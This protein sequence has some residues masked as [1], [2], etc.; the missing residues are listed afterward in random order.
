M[1][2]YS[3]KEPTKFSTQPGNMQHYS[4]YYSADTEACTVFHSFGHVGWVG[5]NHDFDFGTKFTM[6]FCMVQNCIVNFWFWRFTMQTCSSESKL[7][8]KFTKARRDTW[9]SN[10]QSAATSFHLAVSTGSLV[11]MEE[12]NLLISTRPSSTLTTRKNKK[13]VQ[14]LQ[15]KCIRNMST[16][17]YWSRYW[18]YHGWIFIHWA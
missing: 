6:Q 18:I 13:Q 14:P 12:V 17:F 8:R 9:F 3:G 16:F 10:K 15:F 7:V 5:N 1:A 4:E 2:E 11:F